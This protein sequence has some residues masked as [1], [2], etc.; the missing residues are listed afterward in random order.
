MKA[1]GDAVENFCIIR[2]K[3]GPLGDGAVATLES[4]T[5][6]TPTMELTD[7]WSRLITN[8]KRKRKRTEKLMKL[9]EKLERRK[10][11]TCSRPVPYCRKMYLPPLKTILSLGMFHCIEFELHVFRID[12]AD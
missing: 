3:G 1:G 9:Q 2:A 12:R 11:S 7:S 5:E 6:Q 4:R 10:E 8:T